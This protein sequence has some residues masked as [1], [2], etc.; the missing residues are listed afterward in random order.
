MHLVHMQHVIDLPF[1]GDNELEGGHYFILL[2][3]FLWKRA[4]TAPPQS[5]CRGMEADGLMCG[6]LLAGL[7]S[8]WTRRQESRPP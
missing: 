8:N 2:I 7:C 5:R 1:N 6:E 3:D 4:C